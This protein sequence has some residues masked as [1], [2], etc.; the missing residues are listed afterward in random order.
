MLD[1]ENINPDT[2]PAD[3]DCKFNIFACYIEIH[4]IYLM[5][6]STLIFCYTSGIKLYDHLQ[7][8]SGR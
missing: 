5:V 4:L 7:I 6:Y 2:T 3:M 8:N 1:G